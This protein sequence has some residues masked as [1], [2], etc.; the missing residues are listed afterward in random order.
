MVPVHGTIE[1]SQRLAHV[2][3]HASSPR[4]FSCVIQ[5][6]VVEAGTRID[7]GIDCSFAFEEVPVEFL[8]T[9]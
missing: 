4:G 2:V 3:L 5:G 9:R 7:S 1:G 8:R 6:T